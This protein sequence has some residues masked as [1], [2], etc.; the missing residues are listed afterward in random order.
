MIFFFLGGCNF[1]D[2]DDDDDTL[3]LM[4]TPN[5]I[6]PKIRVSLRI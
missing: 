6:H 4:K 3:E 5:L 1:D 2:D